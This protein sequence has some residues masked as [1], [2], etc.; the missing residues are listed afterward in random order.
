MEQLTNIPASI[1]NRRYMQSALDIYDAHLM[2]HCFKYPQNA[3][4]KI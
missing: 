2:N 1:A 3:L 4:H